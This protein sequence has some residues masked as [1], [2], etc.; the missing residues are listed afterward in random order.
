MYTVF[1]HYMYIHVICTNGAVLV[2]YTYT[3]RVIYIYICTLY[4]HVKQIQFMCI[5][6]VSAMQNICKR[7]LTSLRKRKKRC[8]SSF[9]KFGWEWVSG[10]SVCL[11]LSLVTINHHLLMTGTR[12]E[13][14]STS[15]FFHQSGSSADLVKP[16]SA[17]TNKQK[18][19]L[20]ITITSHVHCR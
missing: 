5:F 15:T 3:C 4:M 17:S 7:L 20:S 19:S 10:Y 6:L 11:G 1:S 14:F 13:S 8:K 9:N 16:L 12:T 18:V 2:T